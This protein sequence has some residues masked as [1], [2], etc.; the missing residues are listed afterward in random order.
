MELLENR[1][2][3]IL[4]ICNGFQAL[5][6]LGLL[7]FGKIT[8]IEAGFPTLT[9]NT[10][11]RHQSMLVQTKVCSTLSPWFLC[12]ELGAVHTIPVSHGEGRLVASGGLVKKLAANGQIA[13]QYVDLEG[14]PTMNL[15]H[16]PNGSIAAIEA[17][18]SGDGRVL[19]KMAHSERA[20]NFLYKNVP[21][22]KHQKLFEGGVKYFS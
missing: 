11:G 18:T 3:L 21:G 7:P 10:L 8:D 16:N 2:G 17:L 4:G 5:I 12:E 15:R 13:C 14:K 6:K 9:F 19:G 22:N 1:D 20:G